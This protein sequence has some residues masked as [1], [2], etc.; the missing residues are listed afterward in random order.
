MKEETS[1]KVVIV[2]AE[3][4]WQSLVNDIFSLLLL[5][6]LVWVNELTLGS[7]T[8]NFLFGIFGFLFVVTWFLARSKTEN[9]V[10]RGTDPDDIVE[11]VKARLK[12]E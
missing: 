11:Q 9:R 6:G 1:Y 2:Q 12:G 3:S 5:T 8:L 7:T 4:W 10:I